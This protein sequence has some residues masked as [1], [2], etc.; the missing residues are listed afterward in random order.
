VSTYCLPA[1]RMPSAGASRARG[2]GLAGP[3]GAGRPATSEEREK[4]TVQGRA[5]AGWAVGGDVEGVPGAGASRLG[6]GDGG[7]ALGGAEGLCVVDG[8]GGR[9]VASQRGGPSRNGGKGGPSGPGARRGAGP[10]A[11]LAAHGGGLVRAGLKKVAGLETHWNSP[12]RG[13][14]G[15]ALPRPLV[16]GA[17]A[18]AGGLPVLSGRWASLVSSGR[19][20]GPRSH[21]RGPTMPWPRPGRAASQSS[22]AGRAPLAFSVRDVGACSHSPG[23]SSPGSEPGRVAS[24]NSQVG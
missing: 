8:G 23:L 10:M 24:L 1:L 3:W 22:Q 14:G 4:S 12:P 20:V 6:E 15:L 19:S 11:R 5:C 16:A 18:G 21:T 2:E 9:L 17:G 13:G 7:L